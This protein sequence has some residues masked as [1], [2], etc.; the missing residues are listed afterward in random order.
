MTIIAQQ[1][2]LNFKDNASYLIDDFVIAANNINAYRL[3]NIWPDWGFAFACIIGPRG[4]GKT[5]LATIWQERSGAYL[6][7]AADLRQ[8]V[9]KAASGTSILLDNLSAEDLPEQELFHLLNTISQARTLNPRVSLLITTQT[10]PASWLLNIKDLESRLRAM[11]KLYIEQPGD[12]LLAA[13]LTKLFSDMQ[14][15]VEPKWINYMISRMERTIY[16]AVLCAKACNAM[17]L[18]KK[19]KITKS[20][21]DNVLKDLQSNVSLLG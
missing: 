20:I 16:F 18:A 7:S 8:A 19:S 9:K 15:L 11:P 10:S 17:A 21:I 3:V 2:S 5:H 12:S 13:V 4:V 6:S 14:I 1:L